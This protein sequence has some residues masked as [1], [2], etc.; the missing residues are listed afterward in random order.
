M[1][2]NKEFILDLWGHRYRE[3]P[4]S[5]QCYQ[6]EARY[7]FWPSSTLNEI[8]IQKRL[9]WAIEWTI[10]KFGVHRYEK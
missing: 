3:N 6:P 5:H 7:E 2:F 9:G 8:L 1:L 10:D 4:E